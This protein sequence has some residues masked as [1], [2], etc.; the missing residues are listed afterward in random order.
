MV[1][2]Q[3]RGSP[4]E[5]SAEHAGGSLEKARLHLLSQLIGSRGVRKQGRLLSGTVRVDVPRIGPGAAD[6]ASRSADLDICM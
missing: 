6:R 2:K 5:S 1:A 4:A 3:Y